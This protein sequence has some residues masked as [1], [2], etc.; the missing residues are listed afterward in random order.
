M[1]SSVVA[2]AACA[3]F[4]PVFGI[5]PNENTPYTVDEQVAAAELA[6]GPTNGEKVRANGNKIGLVRLIYIKKSISVITYFT[7]NLIK[8]S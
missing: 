1:L 5:T 6:A 7:T 3:V 8:Y 2:N 4:V